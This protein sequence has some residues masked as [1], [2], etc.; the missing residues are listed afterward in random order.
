MTQRF[1]LSLKTQALIAKL[2]K[3]GRKSSRSFNLEDSGYMELSSLNANLA[4]QQH[5]KR[6]KKK[7]LEILVASINAALLKDLA[8]S[9]SG[10]QKKQKAVKD[11]GL[12]SRLKNSLYPLLII[13][14][15]L[16]FGCDGFAGITSIVTIL[17]LSAPI[18]FSV[19]IVFAFISVLAFYAFNLTE[20]AKNLEIN[21]KEASQLVDYYLKED[22]KIKEIRNLINKNFIK[23]KT[24]EELENDL[25]II[26]L[27]FTRYNALEKGR[28]ALAKQRDNSKLIVSKYLIASL[29]GLFFFSSGFFAGQALATAIA[30]LIIVSTAPIFWPIFAASFAVGLAALGV[31]WFVERPAIDKLVSRWFGLESDK[32]EQ[33]CDSEKIERHFSKL[34]NLKINLLLQKDRIKA[35]SKKKADL[36]AKLSSVQLEINKYERLN[37]NSKEKS[38]INFF[39]KSFHQ[40][41]TTKTIF[42]RN[43]TRTLLEN[44][45]S[46][47]SN[48]EEI[49]SFSKSDRSEAVRLTSLKN[50]FGHQTKSEDEMLQIELASLNSA[51]LKDLA[52]DVQDPLTEKKER[53]RYLEFSTFIVFFPHNCRLYFFWLRW[54][55]WHYL[56]HFYVFDT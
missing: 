27:L 28:E 43:K 4:L 3:Q 10:F 6:K 13:G 35:D 45:K 56:N 55:L 21:K 48:L 31:Y 15:I 42:I 46:K 29:I 14:G 37:T 8:K 17:P 44:F 1:A 24:K 32:I 53:K 49:N 41:S 36:R 23:H 34:E 22:E 2:K 50:W 7:N 54:L 39:S 20:I 26:D 5:L 18:L 9:L 11:K 16:A 19:G 12:S 33:L 47:S 25:Y 51:L 52:I 30:G 38:V 40:K